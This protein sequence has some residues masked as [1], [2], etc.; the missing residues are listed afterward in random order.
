MKSDFMDA[1][2]FYRYEIF[3]SLPLL[4]VP[5]FRCPSDA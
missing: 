1:A 3:Y 2:F 5:F 4:I